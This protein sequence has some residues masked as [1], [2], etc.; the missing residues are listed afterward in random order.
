LTTAVIYLI[1]SRLWTF[2]C[3]TK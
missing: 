2:M 3:T 1:M